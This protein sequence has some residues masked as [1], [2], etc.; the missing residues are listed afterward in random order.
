MSNFNINEYLLKKSTEDILFVYNQK[1]N[2]NANINGF[3][4]ETIT[5]SYEEN[6][7]IFVNVNKKKGSYLVTN[8]NK[9]NIDEGINKAKKLAKLKSKTDLDYF[10]NKIPKK[11]I[12]F[13]KSVNNVCFEDIL[14]DTKKALTKDKYFKSYIGNIQ[15]TQTTTKTIVNKDESGLNKSSISSSFTINTKKKNQSSGFFSEIYTKSKDINVERC[16]SQAKINAN[17]LLSPCQGDKGGYTI[18]FTPEVLS[19]IISH[20]ILNAC[21]GDVI[22]K[23]K[24][25]LK[26]YINKKIF[27]KNLTLV[28]DPHIDYF[29]GSYVVDYEG[30]RTN[31]KDLFKEGVFK[32]PIY[33][34]KY[35]LLTNNKSTGNSFYGISFTNVLQKPGTRQI[36]S[37]IQNTKKGILVY[38]VM[39]LHTNDIVTGDFSLTISSAKEIVNVEY[40]RTVTNLNLTGNIKDLFKE[41]YFSKEQLFF[42]NCLF[43]FG[44]TNNIKLI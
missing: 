22:Y 17:N 33:N 5:N 3:N 30:V 32:K 1:L 11:K 8:I 37:I 39:G 40:K 21:K 27:S 4:Y 7:N 41:M 43:S 44:V 15:K 25:Y 12:I 31:K 38:S 16:L 29:L 2:E 20:F 9:T 34:K 10:G 13:D 18:I 24:S 35:G 26:D 19:E 23:Q 6:I 14:K 36:E 42:G 28:E